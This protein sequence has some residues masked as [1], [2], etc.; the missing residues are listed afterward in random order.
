L[1][2]W[3]DWN[4]IYCNVPS[5]ELDAVEDDGDPFIGL[6]ILQGLKGLPES[7]LSK[8]YMPSESV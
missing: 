4:L 2:P 7:K 5:V 1:K 8:N 3:K 6:A